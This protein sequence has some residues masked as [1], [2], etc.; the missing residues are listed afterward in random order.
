ME[1][2]IGVP[3]CRL[4]FFNIFQGVRRISNLSQRAGLLLWHVK[5]IVRAAH[6]MH[7][8]NQKNSDCSSAVVKN[9]NEGKTRLLV[10]A[11]Q[12]LSLSKRLE[13]VIDTWL[14]GKC[15]VLV[16]NS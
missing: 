11:E 8:L 4:I 1:T 6:F 3:Y 14:E 16:S 7:N 12:A 2:I 15:I 9:T 13:L 5:L 10:S